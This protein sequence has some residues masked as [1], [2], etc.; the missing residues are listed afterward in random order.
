MSIMFKNPSITVSDAFCDFLTFTVP[1][2]TPKEQDAIRTRMS[3][4]SLKALQY[5]C[6]QVGRRRYKCGVAVR[7]DAHSEQTV[8]LHCDPW[9]DN[10][11]FF[12]AEFN[13][14][15]V[16]LT[17]AKVLIEQ[18]LHEDW[19]TV[20]GKAR[21]TRADAAVDI[22]GVQLDELLLSVPKI[23]MSRVFCKGG[24]TQTYEL[25]CLEGGRTIKFYDKRAEIIAK[26][27]K[28]I[29]KDAV[30]EAPITRC[31][32]RLKPEVG[33]ADLEGIENPFLKVRV[34]DYALLPQCD[35]QV[36]RLFKA[37]AQCRG[38]QSALALLDQPDQK[39]VK[40]KL[41][42]AACPWWNPDHIWSG[43]LPTLLALIA[44][45]PVCYLAQMA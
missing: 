17:D 29:M 34:Q 37:V 8:R 14:A 43:W 25:G 5:P 33:F 15:K 9:S 30:P 40:L 38:A 10:I 27:N 18:V 42:S 1:Y 32:I 26:N 36:F 41:A 2:K 13:P 21:V 24:A 16:A 39:Q 20:I 11:A 19:L 31:E 35:E 45:P 12:R 23:Q 28:K 4:G 3:V 6:W 7:V 44:P 22:S